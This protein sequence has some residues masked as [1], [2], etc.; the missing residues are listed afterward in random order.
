MILRRHTLDRIL[1]R[2]ERTI[3]LLDRCRPLNGRGERERLLQEWLR[4]RKRVP[5]WVYPPPGGLSDVRAAL[6]VVAKRSTNAGPWGRL[7]AARALELDAEAAAAEVVGLPEFR[8]RA[9]LRFG[10]DPGVDGSEAEALARSWG[11]EIPP[12]APRE[13][14]SKS[15]D[16]LNPNSL[17]SALLRAVGQHRL[18]FRVVTSA[19]LP[20]AAAT[21]DGILIVRVGMWQTA[22]EVERIVLH[23]IAAHAL[24]RSRARS[25]RLALFRVGTARGSDDE[26]GRALM[27]EER[28]GFLDVARRAQLGRRHL[29]ALAVRAGA[30]WVE[31][32]ELLEKI[33][34]NTPEAVDLAARAHRGG[35]LG[36]EIIYLTAQCRVRRAL[37]QNPEIETWMQRGRISADVAP[38]LSSLGEPPDLFDA[39]DAA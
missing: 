10:I 16:E 9:A 14:L 17:I 3:A 15:D 34:A 12:E 19:D 30:D 31:T 32:V 38:Q 6:E 23:E 35:G 5:A 7:Y 27:L 33:G 29:A 26:E 18:P 21:G 1:S 25:E 20:C 36:R 11:T 13:R 22:R 39:R 8:Q 28:H 24:P 4:G 2:A 37:A